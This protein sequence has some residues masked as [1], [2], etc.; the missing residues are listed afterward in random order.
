[1]K[2]LRIC[3]MILGTVL[4]WGFIVPFGGLFLLT[5]RVLGLFKVYGLFTLFKAMWRGG[6]MI[7]SPHPTLLETLI[8]PVLFGP[9]VYLRPRLYTYSAAYN[10]LFPEVLYGPF[11]CIPIDPTNPRNN[12]ESSKRM[13]NIL[14][15][16]NNLI[17]YVGG[18][19]EKRP[20]HGKPDKPIHYVTSTD[21]TRKMK[22]PVTTFFPV[23]KTVVPVWIDIPFSDHANNLWDTLWHWLRHR[24]VI[25]LS[26]QEPWVM[27]PGS[28]KTQWKRMADS[29]L[30]P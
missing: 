17:V 21:G 24:E 28:V 27:E 11:R 18:G 5:L 10:D 16:N 22:Q 8:F 23:G 4:T 7:I 9:L 13:Q 14:D 26:V 20:Y 12:E 6:C 2:P 19:R 29:L 15:Q 3:L 1:M 25:T 30:N